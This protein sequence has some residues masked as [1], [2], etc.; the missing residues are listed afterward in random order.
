MVLAFPQEF[1]GMSDPERCVD[2][3]TRIGT[4]G[5]LDEAE[6]RSLLSENGFEVVAPFAR[7]PTC[8]EHTI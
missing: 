1:L 5:T 7:D 3:H 8:G 2:V 6:Y 4:V